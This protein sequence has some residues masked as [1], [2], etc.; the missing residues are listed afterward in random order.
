MV[1]LSKLLLVVAIVAMLTVPTNI[2][3]GYHAPITISNP[4]PATGDIFGDS[5]SIS[6]N[7]VLI[8][9][10]SDDAGATNAGSAYLFDATT[11]S[12][13]R[14]FNNPTP[15]TADIFGYS[16]S[17]SGN[18]V[19]VGAL[20]DDTGAS[21]AGSAYLFDATTGSLLRTFNNPTPASGDSFGNSVSLS[22]NNVLIGAYRDNTGAL[23]AG[24]A[25]L[26]DA[27]TGSLLRTFNNP[28]PAKG[29][30]LGRS[31]SVSGNNVL[32]G[33]WNDD[34]GASDAGSAYLFDATTGSLLRTFN[35]PT[36]ASGDSFGVSVSVSSN[37]VLIGAYQDDTGASDAGSAYL[38]DATTGSLLRTFNNPTPATADI[39]GYSVSVSGNVLVGARNDDTGASDAGTAYLF[40][41]DIQSSQ[42]GQASGQ[43][44]VLGTCGLSF[45]N[46]NI[47]SYGPL[48]PNTISPE[49][50]L[51]MTNSGSI[52]SALTVKGGNW[53]D[54]GNNSVMLANRT[55]YNVT[56]G[57]SYAQKLPLQ[58]FDTLVKNPF[59]PSV[60]LQ[61]FWQLQAI[62]LNP[63]FTGSATQ[64]MNFT[65]SC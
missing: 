16:V 7:Y 14:T 5:V 12:L 48:L 65:V 56:S 23:G 1:K 40:L 49:I 30:A 53:K 8:G 42:S 62:L 15:A 31:V 9:S 41:E 63:T 4:A 47:V 21:D 2:A 64:T 58:T 54:S 10:L 44:N 45:P 22:G 33:A 28:T 35:N 29:D 27:T 32:V 3:M 34:T 55:H 60:I 59:Q 57:V 51:N 37:N 46:G 18:Y 52:S 38:F 11:G 17:V 61:T 6:S 26:F 39:F 13:L 19:L 43:V 24:S 25:Y 20:N 36:P 50:K